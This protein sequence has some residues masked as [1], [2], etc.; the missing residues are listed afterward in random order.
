VNP[1]NPW[2][3][4]AVII[5]VV[6]VVQEAV[7]R[8]LRIDGVRPDLMLGLAII[9]AII[10]GPEVGAVAGFAGGLLVDLFVNTPFGLTALVA[11]VIAF[12]VGSVQQTLGPGPRW[13]MPLLVA[14]ASAIAEVTWAALG[15]VLGLPA[16]LHPRLLIVVAVVSTINAAITLPLGAVVRWVYAR[17]SKRVAA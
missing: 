6:F 7:L 10:A 12:A 13:S 2:A 8:G 14:V 1:D 15:T 9:A 5:A 11:S 3:R 4:G 17:T 16:L